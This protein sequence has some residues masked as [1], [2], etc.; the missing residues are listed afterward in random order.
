MA[1]TEQLA[2]GKALDT[3]VPRDGVVLVGWGLVAE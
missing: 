2:V 1:S 3:V